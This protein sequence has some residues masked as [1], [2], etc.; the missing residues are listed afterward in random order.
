MTD[1]CAATGEHEGLGV[2]SKFNA[3]R[4]FLGHLK[5]PG[6]RLGGGWLEAT[7]DNLGGPLQRGPFNPPHGPGHVRP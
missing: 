4:D 2:T 1:P 5:A 7:F 6:P 3:E